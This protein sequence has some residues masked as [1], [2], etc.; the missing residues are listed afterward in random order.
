MRV[1]GVA[2]HGSR[3]RSRACGCFSPDRHAFLLSVQAV[4]CYV[5]LLCLLQA[6]R[7][8]AQAELDARAAKKRAKRQKKK[9]CVSVCKGGVLC[10]TMLHA[11]VISGLS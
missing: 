5:M 8:A 6:K 10:S 3:A 9:V 1:R 7:Q 2:G 11:T 4:L